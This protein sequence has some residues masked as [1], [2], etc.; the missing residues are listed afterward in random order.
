MG[1]PF[2]LRSYP[3]R[4]GP[5]VQFRSNFDARWR[6]VALAR[7]P[8]W[9]IVCRHCLIMDL[10]FSVSSLLSR[11]HTGQEMHYDPGWLWMSLQSSQLDIFADKRHLNQVLLLFHCLH[12]LFLIVNIF[13]SPIWFNFT[14]FSEFTQ[15]CAFDSHVINLGDSPGPAMMIMGY[16]RNSWGTSRHIGS[17][18]DKNR[19]L[20]SRLHLLLFLL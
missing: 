4:E 10:D 14:A 13:M 17:C 16:H 5:I 15:K 1:A 9:E 3:W 11:Q 8:F 20:H 18:Y 12:L 6:D 7:L 2:S 19:S